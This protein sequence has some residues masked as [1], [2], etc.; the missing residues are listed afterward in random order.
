[1]PYPCND[2]RFH[3]NEKFPGI[4]MPAFCS[5]TASTAV[6]PRPGLNVVVYGWRMSSKTPSPQPRAAH[7]ARWP[8]VALLE[9]GGQEVDQQLGRAGSQRAG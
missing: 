5:T 7:P 8:P 3:L 4:H 6:L 9:H 1:M 2:V